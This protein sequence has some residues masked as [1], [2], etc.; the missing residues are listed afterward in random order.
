[1]EEESAVVVRSESKPIKRPPLTVI[2]LLTI[3]SGT[4]QSKNSNL[5]VPLKLST[6]FMDVM[7]TQQTYLK[8]NEIRQLMNKYI[9][10]KKLLK[11]E[12]LIK[13]RIGNN[14]LL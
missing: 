5:F 8:M 4:G 9:N 7:G 6:S 14:Y 1:M 2:Y 13:S 10:D 3:L 12:T 11:V